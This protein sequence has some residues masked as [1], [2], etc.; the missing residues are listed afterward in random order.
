MTPHIYIAAATN[1]FGFDWSGGKRSFKTIDD[2]SPRRK[3]S[4]FE[5]WLSSMLFVMT[6]RASFLRWLTTWIS[7]F[8]WLTQPQAL[9]RI[10]AMLSRCCQRMQ[11]QYHRA[12]FLKTGVISSTTKRKCHHRQSISI[13]PPAY[14]LSEIS[15]V[16]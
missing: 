13:Q 3:H 7:A 10:V 9:S 8:Q 4:L 12:C 14:Q 11:A 5:P 15:T 6:S 16:Y 2:R 1:H